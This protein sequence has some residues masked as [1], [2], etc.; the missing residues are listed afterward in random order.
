MSM[1]LGAGGILIVIVLVQ[2][3]HT[4]MQYSNLVDDKAFRYVNSQE[5]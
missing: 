2:R 5:R 4:N 1:I 3:N